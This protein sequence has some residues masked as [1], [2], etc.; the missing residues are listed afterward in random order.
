MFD[1]FSKHQFRWLTCHIPLATWDTMRLSLPDQRRYCWGRNTWV[2]CQSIISLF[3]EWESRKEDSDRGTVGTELHQWLKQRK[4]S[5]KTSCEVLNDVPGFIL[6][7]FHCSSLPFTLWTFQF[8]TVKSH[9][10]Y[11][12][13][14]KLAADLFYSLQQKEPQLMKFINICMERCYGPNAVFLQH[15]YTESLTPQYTCICRYYLWKPIKLYR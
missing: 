6:P 4:K 8:P 12:Y 15:L 3:W 2:G 1:V 14:L 5:N 9:P 10:F 11:F 7:K 13:W